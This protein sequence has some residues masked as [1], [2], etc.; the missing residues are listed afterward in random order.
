MKYEGRT[1][2]YFGRYRKYSD[3]QGL[4]LRLFYRN[5]I[6]ITGPWNWIVSIDIL[7]GP[8]DL[9]FGFHGMRR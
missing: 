2:H 6:T 7:L 9:Q 4:G 3:P 1:F 5:L 8:F